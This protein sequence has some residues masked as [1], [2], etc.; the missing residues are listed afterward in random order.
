MCYRRVALGLLVLDVRVLISVCTPY[1]ESEV[2]VSDQG[3]GPSLTGI[4]S[5]SLISQ[6][7]PE[8]RTHCS[9]HALVLSRL[10]RVNTPPTLQRSN[11][12]QPL[13]ALGLPLCKPQFRDPN[14]TASTLM[15]DIDKQWIE[16]A[17]WP[18]CAILAMSSRATN[19]GT[20]LAG[21]GIGL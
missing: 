16:A 4:C 15:W 1:D 5:H 7:C 20:L 3:N 8:N 21:G 14:Y 12:L 6:S 2:W 13:A 17:A 11:T 10:P 18:S 19:R 9:T